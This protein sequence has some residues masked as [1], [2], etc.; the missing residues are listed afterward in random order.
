MTREKRDVSFKLLIPII[1]LFAAALIAALPVRSEQEIFD[2]VI[3]LHV[4][5]N[6]DSA[7]D[8]AVK[9]KVRDAIL[10]EAEQLLSGCKSEAEAQT[11]VEA[12]LDKLEAAAEHVLAESGFGY[13]AKVTLGREFYPRRDYEGFYLPEGT[14]LSLRVLLGEASGQNWW[15]VFFPPLCT[16]SAEKYTEQLKEVGFS[17]YQIKLLT[18]AETPRYKLKFRIVELVRQWL[19]NGASE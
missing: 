19:G 13:G 18:E 8:Q 10:G 16:S 11:K 4:V 12:N 7:E 3:R 6:S 17:P 5:A 2:R 1:A 15:C 14:Y 9:L